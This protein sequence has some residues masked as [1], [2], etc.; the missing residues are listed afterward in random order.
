VPPPSRSTAWTWASTATATE[1]LHL[2]GTPLPTLPGP[3]LN[4]SLVHTFSPA[5]E[6]GELAQWLPLPAGL[7]RHWRC[8]LPN[9]PRAGKALMA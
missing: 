3:T 1:P 9:T 2:P 8:V 6:R 4:Q 7:Q 5:L